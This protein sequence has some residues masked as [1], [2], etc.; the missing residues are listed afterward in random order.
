M[1]ADPWLSLM[2]GAAEWAAVCPLNSEALS[3]P[4]RDEL[5]AVRREGEYGAL[6]R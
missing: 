4:P 5:E 3:P 1:K 2:E 6:M